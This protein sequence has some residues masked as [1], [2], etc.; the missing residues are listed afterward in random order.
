MKTHNSQVTNNGDKVMK[1]SRKKTDVYSE[2]QIKWEQISWWKQSKPEDTGAT[3]LKMH[4]R[5][6]NNN[7]TK[8]PGKI[9]QEWNQQT[10]FFRNIKFREIYHQICKEYGAGTPKIHISP[11]MNYIRYVL[12]HKNNG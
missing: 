4:K 7:N 8:S 1:A 2:R 5:K 9:Y 12:T 10:T 6:K 3:P 11:E